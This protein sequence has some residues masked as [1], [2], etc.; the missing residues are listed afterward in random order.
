MKSKKLLPVY[1]WQSTII[2]CN[3]IQMLRRMTSRSTL[4]LMRKT[5]SLDLQK[6]KSQIFVSCLLSLEEHMK[7]TEILIIGWE[8]LLYVVFGSTV[9]RLEKDWEWTGLGLQKTGLQSWSF[10]FWDQRLQKDRYIRTGWDRSEP[11]LQSHTILLLISINMHQRPSKLDENWVRYDQNR[12]K[13]LF[14][15]CF[16]AF[17]HISLNFHPIF[18]IP[19]CFIFGSVSS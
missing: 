3:W 9:S 18:M 8:I 13:H 16:H 19:I 4:I 17:G 10:D 14:L 2:L 6:A 12:V 11:V 1:E 15:P 5:G 7:N